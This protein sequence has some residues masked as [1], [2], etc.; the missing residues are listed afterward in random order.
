[1]STAEIITSGT[2]VPRPGDWVTIRRYIRRG[3]VTEPELQSEQAGRISRAEPEADGWRIWLDTLPDGEWIFTGYQFLGQDVDGRGPASLVTEIAPMARDGQHIQLTPDLALLLD[4]SQC[5]VAE[6]TD[7]AAG[8]EVLRRVTITNVDAFKAA[9]DTLREAQRAELAEADNARV[10]GRGS[11]RRDE[12]RLTEREAVEWLACR[13]H[14]A[15]QA[16]ADLVEG[17]R[18]GRLI[19][20]QLDGMTYD[21]TYWVIP[22]GTDAEAAKP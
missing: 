1:M 13:R 15:C 10:T 9:L 20:S 7:P 5:I 2:Y 12:G 16:A 19:P 4:A 8:G 22:A 21:G 3:L 11:R 14:M 6:V 17:L 18:F